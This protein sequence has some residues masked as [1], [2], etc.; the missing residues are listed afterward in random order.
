MTMVGRPAPPGS[1]PPPPPPPP[2]DDQKAHLKF[3]SVVQIGNQVAELLRESLD[4]S[5]T[6]IQGRE[7][8]ARLVRDYARALRD[9]LEASK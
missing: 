7:A 3:E 4:L 1:K 2:F 8:K 6:T 9:L 5:C